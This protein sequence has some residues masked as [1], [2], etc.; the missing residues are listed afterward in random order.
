[1][2]FKKLF[3]VSDIHG[4]ADQLIEALT[5]AGFDWEN[6]THLL[7]VC[8][9]CFD[10]GRQNRAVLE[11]LSKIENKIL[12]RGNHEDMLERVLCRGRVDQ[13]NISNGTDRTV[14]EFYGKNAIDQDG[15]FDTDRT[16]TDTLFSFMDEMVDYFETEHYVFVHGWVPLCMEY[17]RISFDSEW[18]VASATRWGKARWLEWPRLY[19][20]GLEIPDKILVCGHR[21]VQYGSDFDRRRARN[22]S[23]PF[24][25]KGLIAIDAC[26]VSS[27][28]VNVLVLEDRLMEARRHEMTLL[29]EPFARIAD[30]TKTVEMRLYDEKRQLLR[31]GDVIVFR[32]RDL[33]SCIEARVLGVCAYP[34]FDALVDDFSPIQLGSKGWTREQIADFMKDL[35]GKDKCGRYR[36][37]AI[38][39][40][41][42][43]NK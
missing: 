6:P 2:S 18:R 41:L 5:A 11:Y 27:G 7:I 35:Y 16:I 1:M 25:G 26:T 15:Y 14:M 22:D 12:I 32:H 19:G 24:F 33:A 30:G 28:R 13:N 36:A 4:H 34:D 8:G 17:P 43:K 21:P 9:D 42:L 20:C 38:R 29:D 31:V 40:K 23:T 39:I 3:V 37:A 10:R